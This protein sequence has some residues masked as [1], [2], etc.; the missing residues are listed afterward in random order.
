MGANFLCY[1]PATPSAGFITSLEP[2]SA[3]APWHCDRPEK[4][5]LPRPLF[6]PTCA[7]Y[8][9]WSESVGKFLRR[10][11]QSVAAPQLKGS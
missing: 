3:P 7:L 11:Q 10:Q 2:P 5:F 8:H 6:V 4:R 1:S 9:D